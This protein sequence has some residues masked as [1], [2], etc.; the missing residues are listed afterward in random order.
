[1]KNRKYNSSIIAKLAFLIFLMF[2]SC[3]RDEENLELAKFPNTPEVFIDG[4]SSG[5][6]YAA[7]GGS[8]V[9]A[10][11]VDNQVK[12]QG[13]SSMRFDI[14]NAD[15]PGGGYAAG[16]FLTDDGRDLSEYN[17]LTFWVK[18]TQSATVNEIGFGFTFEEEK[19]RTSIKGMPVTTAWV[20]QIVPIPDASKLNIERGLLYFVDEP[21]NGLGYTFWLDEVKFEKLGTL[22]H[23]EP[24]ILN[25]NDKVET[26]VN[27]SSI[28][29][30]G[31]SVSVNLP[32]GV[33]QIVSTSPAYFNFTSSDNNVAT[34]NE[35]GLVSVINTGSAIIT[36]KL[37]GIDA[38]GSL[39][40]TSQGEFKHA[41]IPTANPADVISLFSNSYTNVPVEYYN[42]YW[43]PYQTT[44][45][46]DFEIDGDDVL[47]YNNFNFVGIQFSAPSINATKM[48][49]LHMD[50][51]IPNAVNPSDKFAVKILD[52]GSNG[53]FDSTDPTK[54]AIF[55]S[56]VPL[57]SGD[58]ISLDISLSGLS[59]KDKLAQIIM[60]NLGSSLSS[61]YLDNIYFYNDGG[62]SG[63]T[64]PIQ[65]APIPNQN[66]GNV[67]SVFS[68]SYNNITGTDFN[69][70]WGQQT[71][72]SE[73]QVDGNNT[74]LYKGLNYQ[75]ITFGSNQD[76]SDM[77]FVHLDYWT[78]NSSALSVFLI[79]ADGKETP[80][81][82]T[83]PSSG[84]TS[85]NI[86]LTEFSQV[87]MSNII[88]FKFEGNGDIYLDNI[89]FYKTNN[90]SSEPSLPLNFENGE[91]LIPFDGGAF[92]LNVDNPDMNG[93]TSAKALEFHKVSGSAWYSG[94]VFDE[95]LR[96]TP[97]IDLSKGT[98]FTIKF[99]SPKEGI[100]VRF[101]LEGGAAPAYEVFQDVN[102]ANQWITLTFDFTS[103][104]NSSDTYPKFAIFPDFD[105]SN[106]V[107]VAV[108]T[109][110]YFDD[111]TQK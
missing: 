64:A 97:I 37:D 11:D 74:L 60:E 40:I 50:L 108:G 73:V 39:T 21:D 5:L 66:A 95:N 36:A 28:A 86:A 91:T 10:F 58:W 48:T 107:P 14:P 62:G 80:Y 71:V 68:D 15:D 42:G 72:V 33:D 98:I 56:P 8:K 26:G 1:M 85:V 57:I 78:A 23:K 69:P 17:A 93:N 2:T 59:S 81:N 109:I 9:T 87:D 27:N 84:W 104:V 38:L 55:G 54:S 24:K 30:D 51:F 96:T 100:K 43:Q 83:V 13:A 94:V 31:L 70:N 34:V 101:Q 49:H 82:L 18:A 6:K 20:K 89:Y 99:W 12:F 106:Q 102:S 88:Q 45:S 61:F 16:I 29:I 103:Q 110:Y 44:L 25:G 92:A 7:F 41:P 76:L 4:F 75:G 53:I 90:T 67:I 22:A 63:S 111:I 32:N 77:Q 3:T 46:A 105:A 19:Y 47:S 79:S 52:L 65:G 35:A